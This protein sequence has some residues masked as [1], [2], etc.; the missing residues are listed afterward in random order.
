MNDE[1]IPATPETDA[2]PAPRWLR[3]EPSPTP[4]SSAAL[5]EADR[6]MTLC[7]SCRY[8]EG[9]CAVFPAM[10][11]QRLRRR[12]PELSPILCHGCGA[13]LHDCQ[14]APPHPFEM[15]V[16]RTLATVRAESYRRYAWPSA[17]AGLFTGNALGVALATGIAVLVFI[18]GFAANGGVDALFT[19]QSGPGAFY[20]QMPHGAMALLFGVTFI[21]AIV[22][23]VLSAR[24]FW[25][26]LHEAG[27]PAGVVG[28]TDWREAARD[29]AALRYLDGGGV[30]CMNDG[31]APDDKRR[32]WHHLTVGGLAL[33][34]AATGVATLYHYLLEREAPYPW[35]DLPVLLGSVGGI[36]IVVGTI[37]LLA[38]RRRRDP[39]L[40]DTAGA[41]MGTAFTSMLLLTAL[42]GLALL[43]ARE[44]AAMGL[45]LA[46]HLGIVL[47]LF[48]SLPYG[49]F[50]HGIHRYLALV[51][52][53][54][55]RRLQR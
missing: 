20:R 50:V 17:L 36:G 19:P 35:W 51:W 21:Y 52:Y 40:V 25:R 28:P 29:A 10:E 12:G 6:L 14:F 2:T 32:R 53:A 55:E 42:T 45:L 34:F 18:A 13:C 30:G 24:R 3:I 1:P 9:V 11:M 26:E 22:A 4:H 47:G 7:N 31:D 41:G 33:C 39:A 5:A 54:R 48:L 8:C 46:I 43:A 37:G 27:G 49:K 23:L 15:N 38:A 16:P 44:T